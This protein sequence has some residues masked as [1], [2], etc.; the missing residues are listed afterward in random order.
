MYIYTNKNAQIYSK[1]G[2]KGTTYEPGFDEAQ[3]IFGD[4]SGKKALDFG[5][6]AGRTT[7]L[8]LSFGAKDAVGVDHNQSMIDQ[9][10]RQNYENAKFVQID[11]NIPFPDNTFDVALCAHVMVE[12]SSLSEMEQIICEV[13]RALKP[14][15]T[16]VII[17]N[18]SQA[19]GKNY[20]SF[21][22]ENQD[23]LVSGQKIPIVIKGEKHFIIDDYFWK[24]EDYQKILEKIG[25][26]VESMTYPTMS[27]EGWLDESVVAPH[28]VIKSSK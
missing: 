11:K 4:L 17:T 16:F 13:Y 26:T 6:G 19:I 2:I 14:G 25:F 21:Q 12:V 10:K 7:E 9:A 20:I 22:Y 1:L 23:H 8:L 27:G 3:R 18:N 15:G 5:S 24:E 28:V